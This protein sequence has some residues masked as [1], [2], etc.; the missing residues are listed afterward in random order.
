MY[1]HHN[2]F[3]QANLGRYWHKYW[4]DGVATYTFT[5]NKATPQVKKFELYDLHSDADA[6]IQQL[7]GLFLSITLYMHKIDQEKA[8]SLA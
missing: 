5:T 8:I 1:P 7:N 2:Y 3:Q 6:L 4:M